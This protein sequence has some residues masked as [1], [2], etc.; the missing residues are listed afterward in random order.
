MDIKKLFIHRIFEVSEH[1]SFRKKQVFLP[2]VE[3]GFR[4]FVWLKPQVHEA[5]PRLS[6]EVST[7]LDGYPPVRALQ[8]MPEN[9][10]HSADDT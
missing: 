9:P 5:S 7:F 6:W 2:A 3:Y 8:R 1:L 4:S 10:F